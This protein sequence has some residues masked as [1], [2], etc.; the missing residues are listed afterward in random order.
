MERVDTGGVGKELLLER[1]AVTQVCALK[2]FENIWNLQM[3]LLIPVTCGRKFLGQGSNLCHSST[4]SLCSD[5]AGSLTF[6]TT[7]EL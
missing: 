7:G 4:Q 5:K 1:V 2:L 6:C 3:F